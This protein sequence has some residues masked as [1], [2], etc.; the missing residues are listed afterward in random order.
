MKKEKIKVVCRIRP[1]NGGEDGSKNITAVSKENGTVSLT[2]ISNS[3]TQK[4]TIG[5]GQGPRDSLKLNENFIFDAVFNEND[6]QKDLFK[7]VGEKAVESTFLGYNGTILCYG[8]T[9]SGK[10]FTMEGDFEDH[11]KK[12]II[13]RSLDF[14]FECITKAPSKLEFS[15]KCSF[16][17]IY[18]EKIY[19]LFDGKH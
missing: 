19:D 10:T 6:K 12:G 11:D 18:N 16:I 3:S 15:I 2:E 13:P 9:S 7:E 5:N 14:I 1:F 4:G 8:Q 17:E